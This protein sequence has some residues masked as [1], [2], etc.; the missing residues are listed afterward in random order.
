MQRWYYNYFSVFPT[1]KNWPAALCLYNL[2]IYLHLGFPSGS[3]GKES[4]QF[5][6]PGFN[7]WV[8]KIPWRREWQPAPVFLPRELHEQRSLVGYHPWGCKESD[9]TEGLTLSVPFFCISYI[10]VNKSYLFFSFWRT[11]LCRQNLCAFT[12]LQMTQFCSFLWPSSIPLSEKAMAPY[13][14]TL[15]W[16][17]P[18]TEKPGRLQSIHFLPFKLLLLLLSC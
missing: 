9:M 2:V 10:S 12:S 15:T 11:L 6:T 8:R 17:I 5:R 13:S 4:C 18:W 1:E 14:S 16:K 3:D 7:P